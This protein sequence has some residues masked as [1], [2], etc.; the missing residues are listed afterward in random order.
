MYK[1]LI[2]DDEK[3]VLDSIKFI[4]EKSFIDVVVIGTA[5]SGREA[6]E[7]A[8][9]LKP[10]IVFMD[11]RMPEINGIEAIREIKSRMN[12]I[13]FTILTACDQFDCAKEAVKLEVVEYLLKPVSREKIVK[14]IKKSIET[15]TSNREKWKK[16][17]ELKERLECVLPVL[18]SSFIK[19]MLV[20]K[21]HSCELDRYRNVLGLEEEGGYIITVQFGDTENGGNVRDRFGYSVNC[22]TFYSYFRDVFK[23][24]CKCLIGP[25]MMNRIF[26]FIPA[27]VKGDKSTIKLEAM[28]IA[29]YVF[30]IL[31]EKMGVDIFIGIGRAHDTLKNISRSYDESL[32]TVN[33]LAY[34]G[35][36]HIMDVPAET[37]SVS[38]YPQVKEKLLLDK[39]ASGDTEVCIQAFNH[40]YDWLF[41]VYPSSARGDNAEA[42]QVQTDNEVTSLNQALQTFLGSVITEPVVNKGALA[43]A[44]SNAENL[45]EES[46]V[47]TQPGQYPQ[48][49]KDAFNMAINAAKSV[50]NSSDVT[51]SQVDNAATAL[52]SAMDTFRAAVNE[53]VSADLNHDG[54][55]DVGDLAIVAYYYGKSSTDSGWDEARIADVVKDSQI[56]ISDLA[57]IAQSIL[58]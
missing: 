56:D 42:T 38:E 14:T 40:I 58:E 24:K 9:T 22:Q 57:Y 52:N 43:A 10:D 19:S 51:Q 23:A 26:A 20:Y 47:G 7:K 13:M 5:R 54:S 12:N 11:I 30:N 41:R 2:A 34:S 36:I 44:I 49:A 46:V 15:I 37:G 27:S 4:I 55:I 35:F 8:E 53:E 48:E 32:R 31:A 3:I 16:E 21:D 39:V 1:L 17:L 18:E 50:Y 33:F 25:F 45:F 6:I 29:E 28:G